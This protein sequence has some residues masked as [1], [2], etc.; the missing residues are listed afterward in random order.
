MQVIKFKR[1]PNFEKILSVFPM[2]A[3]SGTIFAYLDIYV[4]SGHDLPASLI[5]HEAVHCQRQAEMGVD[6]WWDKYLTDPEFRYHEELLAHRAEWKHLSENGSR[7]VRR[8]ALK[9]TAKRLASPLYN[10]MVTLDQ[11]KRDI[12]NAE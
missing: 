10:K 5:A 1:P 11:A 8:Q 6:L 4:P 9:E 3:N 12:Q 7:Q 2:A